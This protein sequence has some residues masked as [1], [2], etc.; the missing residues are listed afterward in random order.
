MFYQKFVKNKFY[1]KKK[2][3]QGLPHTI[4]YDDINL[5]R[6]PNKNREVGEFIIFVSLSV[7]KHVPIQQMLNP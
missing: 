5:L 4:I 2:L 6:K 1:S 7:Y 3:V